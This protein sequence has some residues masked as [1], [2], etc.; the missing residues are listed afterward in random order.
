MQYTSHDTPAAFEVRMS[1]RFVFSDNAGFQSIIEEMNAHRGKPVIL[2]MSG[3][4]FIDSAG[5]GMLLIAH[6]AAS[7]TNTPI[8]LRGA[9]GQVG[10]MIEVSQF[11]T[12]FAA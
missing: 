12:L 9:H 1:G 11:G 5:L 7:E 8:S 4:E 6:E 2:D 3:V 10:Q